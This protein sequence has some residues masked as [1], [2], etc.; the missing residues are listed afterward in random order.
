MRLCGEVVDLVWIDGAQQ[1]D[2]PSAIAQVAVVQKQLR[3]GLV[4]VDVE[5]VDARGVEG[6][7]PA[8]QSVNFIALRE[9]KLCEI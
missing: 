2:K 8:D 5:V 3:V 4:R 9:Q 1:A 7:C 6:G